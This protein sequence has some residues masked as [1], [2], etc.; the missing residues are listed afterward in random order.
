METKSEAIKRLYELRQV[1]DEAIAVLEYSV[2]V[3]HQD[4]DEKAM[5]GALGEEGM[6]P[7]QITTY[8]NA[9]AHM[10]EVE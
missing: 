7:Y 2:P 1:L 9:I 5:Y 6:T 3:E 8:E 10:K 4:D